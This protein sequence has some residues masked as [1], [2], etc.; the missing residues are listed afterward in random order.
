VKRSRPYVILF[1]LIF[2]L[3]IG[4]SIFLIKRNRLELVSVRRGDIEEAVYGLGKIKSNHIYDLKIGVADRVTNLYVKEGDQVQQG[5][6]LAR[7]EEGLLVKAPF[8]GTITTL[9]FHEMEN[10]FPQVV[11]M[12]LED[13]KDLYVEVTLEQQGALRVRH[14]Q[15]AKFS[16]ESLRGVLGLGVVDSIFPKEDQFVVRVSAKE[17]PKEILP[18]MTA[19]VAI[20]VGQKKDVLMVPLASVTNGRVV[21]IRD[22]KKI[23]IEV[24][25]GI[26][27][28]DWAEVSG[29]ALTIGDKVVVPKSL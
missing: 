13:L 28:G 1:V 12:R 7:F 8:S 16:L 24:K 10:V 4:T 5:D 3:G 14:G 6:R 25:V 15:E 21:A 17:F 11:V 29:E 2:L 22:G 26:V 23:K 9:P 18:G 20:Q 27:N 19:D